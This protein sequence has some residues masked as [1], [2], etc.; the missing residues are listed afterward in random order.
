MNIQK[1]N[2]YPFLL[3][4]IKYYLSSPLILS[5]LLILLYFV[6][7]EFLVTTKRFS[8]AQRYAEPFCLSQPCE[9]SS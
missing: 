4:E 2:V 8:E 9:N 7:K 3:Y 1:D 6:L 5:T